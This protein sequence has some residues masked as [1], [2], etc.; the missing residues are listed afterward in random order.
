MA[1]RNDLSAEA[2]ADLTGFSS[3]VDRQGYLL[4][5]QNTIGDRTCRIY[6][7]NASS[8]ATP[9][10]DNVIDATAMGSVGRFHKAPIEEFNTGLILLLLIQHLGSLLITEEQILMVF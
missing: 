5:G 7:Y 1:L 10:G 4:L 9:D 6:H 2:V 8:T 3:A